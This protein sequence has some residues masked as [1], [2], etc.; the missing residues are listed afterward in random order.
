MIVKGTQDGAFIDLWERYHS[1]YEQIWRNMDRENN[2]IHYRVSWMLGTSSA[3]L[4]AEA[5]LAGRAF[6]DAAPSESTGQHIVYVL[7]MLIFTLGAG[8]FTFI[9]QIGVKAAQ[10]QLDHLKRNY[11]ETISDSGKRVFENILGLPRPFGNS[12]NH[13][14]G[15]IAAAVFPRIMLFS[16]LFLGLI[17]FVVLIYFSLMCLQSAGLVNRPH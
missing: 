16:W 13:K 10:E 3:V 1:V 4:T 9:S 8:Y 11:E 15:N 5:F 7:I 12:I 14:R 17:Q 2:L 6:S